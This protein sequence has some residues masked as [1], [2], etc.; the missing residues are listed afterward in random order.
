MSKKLV[1]LATLICCA[2][3]AMQVSGMEQPDNSKNKNIGYTTITVN[4]PLSAEAIPI[5]ARVGARFSITLDSNATTGY[6]W[7]LSKAP[8][9]KVLKPTGSKYYPPSEQIPGRGGYETWNF[10]TVGKGSANV[11]LEYIRPW[12]KGVPPVKSQTFTISIQ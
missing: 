6:K 8:D 10:Q 3:I 1:I 12:E 7:R 11:T 9:A 5:A 2:V 4:S